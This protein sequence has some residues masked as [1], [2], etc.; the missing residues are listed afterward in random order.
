MRSDQ[1]KDRSGELLAI[2]IRNDRPPPGTCFF[3]HPSDELQV[4]VMLHPKGH[5]I[6]A[7]T[8][9]PD[10]RAI[11]RTSEV[12]YIKRGSVRIDF[13]GVEM[14]ETCSYL[15]GSLVLASGDLVILLSG[16]HGLEM[17]AETEIIEV[18]QGPHLNDKVP[19][20]P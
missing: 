12:L 2:I 20:A 13:Y 1:I 4:G 15:V 19:L 7:H 14:D 5:V 6:A 3:T 17:L 18:K 8:H 11:T 16:G 10:A 9:N